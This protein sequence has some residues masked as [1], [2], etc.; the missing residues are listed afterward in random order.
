MVK[1][2]LISFLNKKEI[3]CNG[4]IS[5]RELGKLIIDYFKECD[6][7]LFTDYSAVVSNLFKLANVIEFEELR[8]I[9]ENSN[10]VEDFLNNV[11]IG[12]RYAGEKNEKGYDYKGIETIQENAHY[13]SEQYIEKILKYSDRFK[14]GIFG[15]QL[16]AKVIKAIID[17]SEMTDERK[18]D[19]KFR[20]FDSYI[21]CRIF[22]RRLSAYIQKE[23]GDYRYIDIDE[24]NPSEQQRVVFYRALE[25][26]GARLYIK[27]D[28]IDLN[29][30]FISL[31]PNFD[32]DDMKDYILDVK[33]VLESS[34]IITVDFEGENKE[35]KKKST[36][37]EFKSEIWENDLYDD[38]FDINQYFSKELGHA[39]RE[40]F[41][42][43][44]FYAEGIYGRLESKM[45]F[46]SDFN[47][48][49]DDKKIFIKMRESLKRP[50]NF[51]GPNINNICAIIG[52]NG[53]GKSSVFRMLAN[54]PI[55]SG[56]SKEVYRDEWGDFL[57]IYKLGNHYYYSK[58][59]EKEIEVCIDGMKLFE[60]NDVVNVNMCLLSNTFDPFSVKELSE[61]EVDHDNKDVGNLSG[62]IDFTTTNMLKFGFEVYREMEE[63]RINNL[64]EFMSKK[65]SE[66]DFGLRE[67]ENLGCLSSGEYA[68][69]SLF[70]R[71]YS[72][73]YCGDNNS[74]LQEVQQKDNFI[75]LLDEAELYMHPEWQRKLINDTIEFINYINKDYTFFSNMMIVFSSNSPFLMSDL[76]SENIMRLKEKQRIKTFGQNIYDILRGDFFMPTEPMGAFAYKKIKEAFKDVNEMNTTDREQATYIADILGD[77]LFVT[78]LRRHLDV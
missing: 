36:D 17:Y 18:D 58:S 69:W 6:Y 11:T 49:H 54:N 34:G 13:L 25:Y 35:N 5:N 7:K 42:L 78:M 74:I 28:R 66:V 62:L 72:L 51:Y 44:Y 37:L 43:I 23:Y 59:I 68:R 9:D 38:S 56:K 21:L 55:F 46:R 14:E 65:E 77:E 52:A 53:S 63:E 73:F 33:F 70:S 50:L 22:M 45:C 67:Y 48:V 40:E 12:L 39:S 4:N 8:N 26:G 15:N 10:Y 24:L 31:T 64:K 41:E 75:L 60:N 30:F 32:P 47:V 2:E 57:I 19:M 61:D 1:E 29:T 20:F 71:I 27:V 3:V 16:R 76:P